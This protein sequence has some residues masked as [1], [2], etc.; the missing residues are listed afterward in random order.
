MNFYMSEHGGA[1]L[2]G[3]ISG[4][5]ATLPLGGVMG[6]AGQLLFGTGGRGSP[7]G[8]TIRKAATAHPVPSS[9]AAQCTGDD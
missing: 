5:V 1:Y 3:Q 9:L 8:A 4:G 7:L 6:R 2:G